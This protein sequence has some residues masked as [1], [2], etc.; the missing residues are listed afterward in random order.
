MASFISCKSCSAPIPG[1]QIEP[2]RRIA[3][4]TACGAVFLIHAEHSPSAKSVANVEIHLKEDHL[5]VVRR[6]YRPHMWLY[7]MMAISWSGVVA[8]FQLMQLGGGRLWTAVMVV[9]VLFAV[10]L[11][12]GSL[13]GLLNRTRILV[14]RGRLIKRHF[15]VPWHGK[16][17]LGTDQIDQFFCTEGREFRQGRAYPVYQ[18]N[19]FL[20][21]GVRVPILRNVSSLETI[22]FLENQI[23]QFLGIEDRPVDGETF[24]KFQKHTKPAE[25]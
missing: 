24:K 16:L 18:L 23:E 22:L 12:Y 1:D 20:N 5:K 3:H 2:A 19:V 11:F 21:S 15:P 17:K 9:N 4:C 25:S 10:I 8:G 13:A 7:L 6:W 14:G